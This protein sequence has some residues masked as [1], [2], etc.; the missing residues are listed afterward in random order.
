MSVRK[1]AHRT[2]H[3]QTVSK[4]QADL[5]LYGYWSEQCSS[6]TGWPGF[7]DS[8]SAA[9]AAVPTYP[10]LSTPLAYLSTSLT[11]WLCFCAQEDTVRDTCSF[12][13]P[14]AVCHSSSGPP[15]HH[16]C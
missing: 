5:H 12:G 7:L 16:I 11:H 15:V 13:W 1:G 8:G 6:P 9:K 10:G 2:S 14:A 4:Q 3:E